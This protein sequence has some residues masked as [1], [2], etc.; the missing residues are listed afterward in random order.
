[1]PYKREYEKWADRLFKSVPSKN[2]ELIEQ[3]YLLIKAWEKGSRDPWKDFD[4][5]LL[6]FK[7]LISW[8]GK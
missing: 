8:L 2:P 4:T 1:M 3:T 5:T 6:T 7:I